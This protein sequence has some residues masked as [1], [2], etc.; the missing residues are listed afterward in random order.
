M[1]DENPS[2][3]IGFDDS[4]VKISFEFD[5]DFPIDPVRFVNAVGRLI[6]GELS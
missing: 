4:N 5:D 3:T 6:L 1:D 2:I